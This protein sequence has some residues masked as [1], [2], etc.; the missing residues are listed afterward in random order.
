[1][2][3]QLAVEMNISSL[4]GT[5]I[6]QDQLTLGP[7]EARHHSAVGRLVG[8]NKCCVRAVHSQAAAEGDFV[9]IPVQIKGLCVIAIKI[10]R[11]QANG[12]GSLGV[13][14]EVNG[15][16]QALAGQ[17][18]SLGAIGSPIFLNSFIGDHGLW[19]TRGNQNLRR[20]KF[21]FHSRA[22]PNALNIESLGTISKTMIFQL[23]GCQMPRHA[24]P[25]I[26]GEPNMCPA[27]GSQ[28]IHALDPVGLG[29]GA[30][31]GREESGGGQGEADNDG[32]QFDGREG[33]GE[34]G[35][36]GEFHATVYS[37]R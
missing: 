30:G 37:S 9:S 12:A 19:I 23:S 35:A 11:E 34:S 29:L 1:M 14:P 31:E 24:L 17:F 13:G 7:K 2:G 28:I 16:A 6:H 36:A 8:S 32:G 22:C 10:A 5:A 4:P 20:L 26:L 21:T 33:A 3:V 15:I 18:R 27:N 25:I